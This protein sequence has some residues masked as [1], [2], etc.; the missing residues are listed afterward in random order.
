VSHSTEAEADKVAGK[1]TLKD[2]VSANGE[3]IADDSTPL[4]TSERE[5]LNQ[6]G[7]DISIDL[8]DPA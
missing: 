7:A 5:I 1:H 4:N 8:D 3:D 2:L 6:Q